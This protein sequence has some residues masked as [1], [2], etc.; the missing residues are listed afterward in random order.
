MEEHFDD[1]HEYYDAKEHIEDDYKK[2]SIDDNLNL[3]IKEDN[4]YN[5]HLYWKTEGMNEDEID[6]VI[7]DALKH[8]F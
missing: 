2:F 7:A 1:D 8:E 5:H 4:I 6:K 3:E